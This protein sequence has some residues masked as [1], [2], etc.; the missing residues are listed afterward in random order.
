MAPPHCPVFPFSYLKSRMS[1]SCTPHLPVPPSSASHAP[2]SPHCN[3]VPGLVR[4]SCH[5]HLPN[6]QH[7]SSLSLSLSLQKSRFPGFPVSHLTASL[8][9]FVGSPPPGLTLLGSP[10]PQP[11]ALFSFLSRLSTQFCSF[12]TNQPLAGGFPLC[13]QP[14]P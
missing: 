11:K 1:Y 2:P 5:P 10:R 12:E 9:L 8:V 13:L 4:S 3:G 14:E 7:S 6:V